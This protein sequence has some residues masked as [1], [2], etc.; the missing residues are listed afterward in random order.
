MVQIILGILLL[1]SILIILVVVCCCVVIAVQ[2][3]YRAEKMF[4]EW[5][6]KKDEVA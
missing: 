5:T 2:S 1:I 3:D 4:V 6:N